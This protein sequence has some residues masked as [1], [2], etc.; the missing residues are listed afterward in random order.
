MYGAGQKKKPFCFDN[1]AI[2]ER[3]VPLRWYKTSRV[4]GT[5]QTPRHAQPLHRS[6]TQWLP[7][8]VPYVRVTLSVHVTNEKNTPCRH[9]MYRFVSHVGVAQGYQ[10]LGQRINRKRHIKR[11]IG[12]RE[13]RSPNSLYP[14][15]RFAHATYLVTTKRRVRSDTQEAV[16]IT[17]AD[18]RLRYPLC[19]EH[20][21]GDRSPSHVADRYGLL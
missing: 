1:G 5:C 14:F 20:N 21:P 11:H 10:K 15:T 19:Y 13:R 17:T 7:H 9:E 8:D 6:L 16:L 3:T 18:D 4:A 12:G 2:L